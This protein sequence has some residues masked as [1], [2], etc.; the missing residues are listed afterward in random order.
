MDR[1]LA[2]SPRTTSLKGVETKFDPLRTEAASRAALMH[3]IRH[4]IRHRCHFGQ[5]TQQLRYRR[6][7]GGVVVNLLV[8]IEWRPSAAMEKLHEKVL[9]LGDGVVPFPGSVAG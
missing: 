1:R 8:D 7:L 2:L 3:G 4:G 6:I 9:R 5:A